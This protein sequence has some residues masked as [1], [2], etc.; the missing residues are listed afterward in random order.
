MSVLRRLAFLC[1]SAALLRAV[2]LA[3]QPKAAVTA[4]TPTAS[5]SRSIAVVNPGL[6]APRPVVVTTGR[7]AM[8]GAAV[9]VTTE[10]LAMTGAG[11]EVKTLPLTMTGAATS[12]TTAKLA[13]TGAAVEVTTGGLTMTGTTPAQ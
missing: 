5:A 8:T 3:A 1:A 12:V 11:V 13:M 9:A 6:F 10:K 4:P 2:P 7:L